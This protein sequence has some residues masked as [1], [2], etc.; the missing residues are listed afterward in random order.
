MW[1]LV[2]KSLASHGQP[3]LKYDECP[4]YLKT[5]PYIRTGYRSDQSWHQCLRSVLSLHNETL[6]IWTHLLGFVFF[7]SL[8]LWDFV[9]PPIPHRVTWQDITVIGIII[10]CYQVCMILS[11]VFHTFSS[12]SQGAHE[13]C[14]MMDLAGVMIS[15]TASF[16]CGIYYAFWC[17]PAW[18]TFY[19][20]TVGGFILFGAIFRNVMN[21]DENILMRL[22]YFCSFT[23]YGFI[24]TIHWVLLNGFY[25]DEVK[26]FLPR[27]L[28]F[29]LFCGLAFLFYIAKF[30]ES[31][32]P[33]KFDIWGSSHQWWHCFIWLSLAYM[34]HTGFIFA[35][36]RLETN[37][38]ANSNKSV[39]ERYYDKFYITL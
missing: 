30:P 11:A 29:Y 4:E 21:K 14:L 8:L 7:L 2:T 3:L 18:C 12:H 36:F 20:T 17:F 15:I 31:V 38:S 39:I 5:N 33:G 19:M 26:I 34:H 9:S 25:S 6:N 32:L 24:P 23:V 16:L 1:R 28:I 37:C 10:G 27:I 13:F 35:E 22:V